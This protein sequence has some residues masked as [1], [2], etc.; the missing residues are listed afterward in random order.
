MKSE[1]I[2]AATLGGDVEIERVTAKKVE[3]SSKA[4]GIK[5]KK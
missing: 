1:R 4:G 5:M 2:E 3:G